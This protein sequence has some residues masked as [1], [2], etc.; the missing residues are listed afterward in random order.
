[1]LAALL[2]AKIKTGKIY[3][4]LYFWLPWVALKLG[5]MT[6]NL[7]LVQISTSKKNGCQY[8]TIFRLGISNA[9]LA[10]QVD[11]LP[12]TFCTMMFYRVRGAR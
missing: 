7:V 3:M 6:K 8:S 1:M 10:S 12:D 9:V 5:T 11:A 2:P 4:L